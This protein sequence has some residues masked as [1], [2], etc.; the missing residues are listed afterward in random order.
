MKELLPIGSREQHE[1]AVRSAVVGRRKAQHARRAAPPCNNRAS[2]GD[3]A[4]THEEYG[5]TRQ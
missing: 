3:H 5:D 4:S 2:A 1:A